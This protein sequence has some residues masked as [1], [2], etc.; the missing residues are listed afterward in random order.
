M[1]F[2]GSIEYFIAVFNTEKHKYNQSHFT[3]WK[4]RHST[5]AKLIFILNYFDIIYYFTFLS[6]NHFHLI[7][8]GAEDSSKMV[9]RW[10][11]SLSYNYVHYSRF[12]RKSRIVMIITDSCKCQK[13]DIEIVNKNMYKIRVQSKSTTN[14]SK[15]YSSISFELGYTVHGRDLVWFH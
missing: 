4:N 6:Q 3:T 8:E 14:K 5:F 1:T 10:T 13:S 9:Y 15:D 2:H 7:C 11:R 12:A